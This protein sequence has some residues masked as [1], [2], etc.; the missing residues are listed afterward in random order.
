MVRF[1]TLAVRFIA[2]LLLCYA[3][4]LP[5]A[6]NSLHWNADKWRERVSAD[7]TS[8]DLKTLLENIASSTGWDI[9]V[10]PDTKLEISTK[11]KDRPAGEALRLLLGNLSFVV[12][13]QTNGPGKLY[14][15]RNTMKEATELVR[16]AKKKGGPI[17]NELIVTLKPGANIDELAKAHGAKVTGRLDGQHAYRLEFQDA[18]AADAARKKLEANGDVDGFE[19][20]YPI[21]RPERDASLTP[22]SGSG[23]NLNIRPATEGTG[24]KILPVDVYGNN[25]TTTTFQMAQGILKALENG[26]TFI[27]LS[28]GSDMNSPLVEQ[29]IREASKK[30]IQFFAAAGNQPTGQPVYPAAIPEVTAV[31]ALG[32][33]GKPAPWANYGSFV[34]ALEPGVVPITFNGVNYVVTG[35]SPAT[36]LATGGTAA[37]FYAQ[38][39]SKGPLVIG[40]ID[41]P[42][43][44][45]GTPA[46]SY[47]LPQLSI[48]GDTIAPTTSDFPTHGTTMLETLLMGSAGFGT[49]PAKAQP[50]SGSR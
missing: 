3:A 26:A 30:G 34:D 12:M 6:N 18:A 42:V 47:V 38:N 48:V 46:D 24:I 43:Q 7:I 28:L 50:S 41:T 32:P 36:A 10:E 25:P 49:P 31:S 1:R 35:T 45:S 14:V 2:A 9:Y 5:A 29:I 20:N 11:F 21:A 8:W 27:N 37:E 39:G 17:D 4:Q 23:F 15:F 19:S 33:D 13:P 44:K 16:S 40:L 22:G